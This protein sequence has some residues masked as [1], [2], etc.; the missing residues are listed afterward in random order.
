M[1]E[2]STR[3][4]FPGLREKLGYMAK[5]TWMVDGDCA[6]ELLWFLDCHFSFPE[7]ESERM[8]IREE[9]NPPPPMTA[10]N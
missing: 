8:K 1:T 3:R 2:L 9:E 5:V 6:Y 7:A 4:P 10:L